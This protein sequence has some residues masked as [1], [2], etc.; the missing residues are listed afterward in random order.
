MLFRSKEIDEQNNHLSQEKLIKKSHIILAVVIPSILLIAL[1][2]IYSLKISSFNTSLG[3]NL[4][5]IF[6]F[7]IVSSFH[8]SIFVIFIKTIKMLNR[9]FSEE[10]KEDLLDGMLK[11]SFSYS[12][13]ANELPQVNH[14]SLSSPSHYKKKSLL[15]SH[16][17]LSLFSKLSHLFSFRQ[18]NYIETMIKKFEK[19]DLLNALRYA[20]PINDKQNSKIG[21]ASCRERVELSVVGV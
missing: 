8:V 12:I 4:Y 17:F 5:K 16:S 13:N 6:I 10:K 19:G 7:I 1:Y 3:K 9:I 18:S 15:N 2:V 11:K 21:R 20:L 14:S